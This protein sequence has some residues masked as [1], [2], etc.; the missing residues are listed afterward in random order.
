MVRARRADVDVLVGY[1]DHGTPLLSDLDSQDAIVVPLL[2]SSGFHVHSDIPAAARNARVAA[3]VGP[4]RV[5]ASILVDR[6]RE[7][8][9][10]E[11]LPVVLAATGSAD[12]QSNADV[13]SAADMLAVELGVPVAAAFVAGGEP[14][15]ADVRAVAVASYLLAPGHFAET[16]AGCGAAVV[17]APIGADPRLVDVICA[18]YDAELD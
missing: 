14:P 17:S 6:L 12:P 15:L 1:L 3:A 8:G 18:R 11:S 13:R 16:I 2:L 10:T 7:S 4:D 9:W 5:I